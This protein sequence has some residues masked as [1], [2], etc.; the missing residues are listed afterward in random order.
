MKIIEEE[1]KSI[2]SDYGDKI[3]SHTR[4]KLEKYLGVVRE[5]SKHMIIKPG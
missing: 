3:S 5:M 2:K 1:F 4:N